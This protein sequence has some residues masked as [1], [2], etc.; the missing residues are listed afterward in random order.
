MIEDYGQE[1]EDDVVDKRSRRLKLNHKFLIIN[2][3][4]KQSK[5]K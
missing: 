1:S 2:N 5:I 4:H 3:Y